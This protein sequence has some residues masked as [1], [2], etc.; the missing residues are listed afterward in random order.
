MNCLRRSSTVN[1]GRHDT[2]D[3]GVGTN[4][5]RK[6]IT[7]SRQRRGIPAFAEHVVEW[8]KLGIED[9]ELSTKRNYQAQARMLA[10]RWPT[11]RVD[12]ITEL[13]I[14]QYLAELRDAGMSPS[15]RELPSRILTE[16]ELMLLLAC[17]PGWLYRHRH[18]RR[19]APP[20]QE[21]DRA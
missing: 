7:V 18:R 21:Q 1:K 15:T 6:I 13:M 10:R 2:R 19:V 16:P 20:P 8:A 3:N 5:P 17:L 14:R 11:E 4:F 9:G 12:E